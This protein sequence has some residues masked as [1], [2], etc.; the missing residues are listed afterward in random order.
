MAQCLLLAL[1]LMYP[2]TFECVFPSISSPCFLSRKILILWKSYYNPILHI[3]KYFWI[4]STPNQS[5]ILS[6]KHTHIHPN[7]AV[8]TC[9]PVSIFIPNLQLSYNMKSFKQG[10]RGRGSALYCWASDR[11]LNNKIKIYIW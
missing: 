2:L 6:P 1:S 4:S 3:S 8:P 9:K 10:S 11:S 5:P 7:I